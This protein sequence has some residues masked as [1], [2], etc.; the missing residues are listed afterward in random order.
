MSR[1]GFFRNLRILH[2][3]LC[4]FNGVLLGMLRIARNFGAHLFIE[5][6][7]QCLQILIDTITS[8]NKHLKLLLDELGLLILVGED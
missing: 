3:L 7:S 1:F 8:V 4:L 2:A 6:T 5:S